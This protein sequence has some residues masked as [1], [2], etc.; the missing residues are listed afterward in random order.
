[1]TIVRL[2]LAVLIALTAVAGCSAASSS[3]EG[4]G[5]STGQLCTYTGIAG[6]SEVYAPCREGEA[7]AEKMT[8][9]GFPDNADVYM[10][11]VATDTC[12]RLANGQALGTWSSTN[13]DPEVNRAYREAEV[14]AK[15]P[16]ALSG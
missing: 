10:P 5:G 9:L 14:A 3:G 2:V 1:M 11:E 6:A 13:L 15:C 12:N 4:D 7:F 16:D 8:E